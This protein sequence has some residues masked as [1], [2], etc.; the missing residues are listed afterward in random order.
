MHVFK[1]QSVCAL[2]NMI[3]V[4]CL[5]FKARKLEKM[6]DAQAEITFFGKRNVLPILVFNR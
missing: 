1:S 6:P 3:P 5:K 2:N 4:K